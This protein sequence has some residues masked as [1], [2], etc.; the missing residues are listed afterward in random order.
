M[1]TIQIRFFMKRLAHV[2]EDNIRALQTC[3]DS[4]RTI[5]PAQIL[6]SLPDSYKCP[7][8]VL[9]S[10]LGWDAGTC[11]LITDPDYYPEGRIFKTLSGISV[12]S[13]S[14]MLIADALYAL[15]IRFVYEPCITIN[16]TI[17]HPD[18]A[19]FMPYTGRVVLWEHFGLMDSKDYQWKVIRKLQDYIMAGYLPGYDLIMT[20][21]DKERKLSSKE[22]AAIIE[23]WFLRE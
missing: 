12:R 1:Q 8:E 2:C 10:A 3:I 21:E 22:V 11:T 16:G 4:L 14:E 6:Q 17:Y 20:F 15:G 13:K 23:H 9:Y 19:I 18:F 5:D 7:P